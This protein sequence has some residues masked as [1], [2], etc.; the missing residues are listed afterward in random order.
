MNKLFFTIAVLLLAYNSF[1]QNFE[2][3]RYSNKIFSEADTSKSVEYATAPW[4]NN[5]ISIPELAEYN[6]H[7]GE[8]TTENRSLLMDIFTPKNDTVTNRPAIIFVHGGAFLL[9]TRHNED[10]VA[11]C[12]SFAKMGYVTASIEYRL[13]VGAQVTRTLGQITNINV[14]EDNFSR[15]VY[16][17]I[18]D[19]RAAV[20]FLKQNAT[21]YGID[22][23]LIYMVGSSAGGF[24]SLHNIYMDKNSEIPSAASQT[25]D[26]GLLDAIGVSGYGSQTKAVVPFWAAIQNTN[27][28]ED[29]EA[30]ALLIHGTNDDIVPYKKG[31][32]LSNFIPPNPVLSFNIP[33]TYGSYCIDTALSNKSIDH[34]TYFV[35]GESHEFYGVENG[36]FTPAGPNN[37]WDTV[38][39]KTNDFLFKQHKPKADFSIAANNLTVSLSNNSINGIYYKWDFG[40]SNGSNELNPTHTYSTSGTYSVSLI[41]QN[42]HYAWDT[43]SKKVNVAEPGSGKSVSFIVKDGAQF[44]ENANILLTG[45]GNKTTDEFGKAIFEDIA[46][47]NDIKY[48]VNATN[49]IEY[50]DSL[51]IVDQD[52]SETV[53]LTKSTY[54][55]TFTVKANESVYEGATVTLGSYGTKTTDLN[56]IVKFTGILPS[57]SIYYEVNAETYSMQSG[58]IVITN[59][60]VSKEINLVQEK[61]KVTF[62]VRLGDDPIVGAE[63][64]FNNS[65]KSTN[66]LGQAVFENVTPGINL[67]YTVKVTGYSDNTGAVSVY[68][69]DVTVPVLYSKP[70][71]SVLFVITAHG[72]PLAGANVT[73][74]TYGT[75]T[76]DNSG[77]ARFINVAQQENIDYTITADGHPDFTGKVSV[78]DKDVEEV[79]SITNIA[80]NEPEPL[81]FYPNP[82]NSKLHITTQ[83][84]GS[85]QLI[86]INGKIMLM[87][88]ITEK[89]SIINV[90]FL[91]RGIYFLR[92]TT[93][94]FSIVEKMIK[95]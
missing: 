42:K 34:E 15:A 48:I 41:I 20:R 85:I 55:V 26:L 33:E 7:E 8:T 5:L 27:L 80:T 37:Y 9:G 72:E 21:S 53:I 22:T 28:I 82:A 56:G 49:Y 23:N 32:P 81:I 88:N 29:N 40:D 71:Y 6:I 45:Y 62:D 68:D 59:E 60:N 38:M 47:E 50:I 54:E 3:F 16:R 46:P 86:D 58:K 79:I 19:G 14:S 91:N 17:G 89:E 75:Q 31:A 35:E 78:V 73:L 10:M 13:G 90:D 74:G 76:S 84:A 61:Y 93:E 94:K 1:A 77:F 12:D 51:S 83:K 39:W 4:L 36:D 95:N 52:I 25:P 65:T 70:S 24:V 69:S 43:I 30:P 67:T 44:I 92:F 66:E 11:L 63:V 18:Q 87:Q 57:D 64:I 2:Q